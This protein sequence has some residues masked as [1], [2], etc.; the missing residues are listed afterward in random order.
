MFLKSLSVLILSMP[1]AFAGDILVKEGM[2]S[3]TLKHSETFIELK[4]TSINLS[5]VKKACNE[6]ML[7]Q[8]NAKVETALKKMIKQVQPSGRSLKFVVDAREFYTP[9]D[10]IPGKFFSVVPE[11]IRRM[12]IEES[13]RCDKK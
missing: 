9:M 3:Y 6:K 7:K 1:L 2:R 5:L 8:F 4:A 10:S 11:E 12:K 13:L